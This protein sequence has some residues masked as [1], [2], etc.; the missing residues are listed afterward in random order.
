M[1]EAEN[2]DNDI[3]FDRKGNDF[4]KKKMMAL[5]LAMVLTLTSAVPVLA[6]ES[7]EK[8]ITKDSKGNTAEVTA[9]YQNTEGY[10][11]TIPAAITVVGMNDKAAPATVK[12]E[13]VY[14]GTGENLTVSVSS[15]NNWSVKNS[16]QDSYEYELKK[17][18]TVGSETEESASKVDDNGKVLTVPAGNTGGSSDLSANLTVDSPTTSDAYTD[19]LTFTVSVVNN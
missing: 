8:E 11:V 2:Y 9:T 13:N 16:S 17:Q 15:N 12:A 5:A 6:K 14:I 1:D 10:T 7:T 4:M 18:E 19:N 3:I